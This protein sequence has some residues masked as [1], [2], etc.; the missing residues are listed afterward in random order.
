M[1]LLALVAL[2]PVAFIAAAPASVEERQV[3][4]GCYALLVIVAPLLVSVY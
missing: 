3:A 2:L 1:Q 4:S